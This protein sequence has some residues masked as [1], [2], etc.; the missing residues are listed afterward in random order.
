M[1]FK[2]ES[3]Y[4]FVSRYV[5]FLPDEQF[6][7]SKDSTVAK[8][9]AFDMLIIHLKKEVDKLEDNGM[10]TNGNTFKKQSQ[11]FWTGNKTE[12][13]E[14]IYA[15]YSAGKINSGT[16]DIKELAMTFEEMFNI[17]LGDFYRTFLEIRS[18]KINQT[19]FIDKLK[20]SLITKMLES[21]E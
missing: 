15:L 20:E 21:D 14:L 11:L 1:F 5:S 12:L 19:K 2:R 7:T 4:A 16:A 13:V 8:I 9:L 17:N 18:R 10:E 3:K 6:S